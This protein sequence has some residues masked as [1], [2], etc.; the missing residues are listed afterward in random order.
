[1]RITTVVDLFL[2]FLKT[3]KGF[4]W[5]KVAGC[6]QPIRLT[7]KFYIVNNGLNITICKEVE[8]FGRKF[9]QTKDWAN[10]MQR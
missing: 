10:K 6:N 9:S 8:L 2:I 4:F 5:L 7:G 1:M 3:E